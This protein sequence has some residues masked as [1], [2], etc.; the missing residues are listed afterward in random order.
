MAVLER[1]GRPSCAEAGRTK[2]YSGPLPAIFWRDNTPWREVNLWI[3]QKN[4]VDGATLKSLITHLLAYA[5][6]L[7]E[8]DTSW[9]HFPAEKEKRSLFL[10]RSFLIREIG[11]GGINR[12]TAASRIRAIV[13]FYR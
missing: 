2:T 9:W 12:R 10:Y 1:V 4:N 8:T 7:E 6:W 13:Q 11:A 3:A 5:K